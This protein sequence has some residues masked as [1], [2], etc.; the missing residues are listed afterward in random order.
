MSMHASLR[1]QS[2]R[3]RDRNI[4]Q[5]L[6]GFWWFLSSKQKF[7]FTFVPYCSN[8]HIWKGTTLTLKINSLRFQFT[9]AFSHFLFH[10]AV[11]CMFFCQC[12][13]I[14]CLSTAQAFTKKIANNQQTILTHCGIQYLPQWPMTTRKDTR[15]WDIITYEIQIFCWVTQQNNESDVFNV[16]IVC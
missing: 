6:G 1:P 3:P 5:P 10:F 12:F 11:F 16:Y 8:L 7:P 13:Q 2:H 15:A 9:S 14:S 4:Y